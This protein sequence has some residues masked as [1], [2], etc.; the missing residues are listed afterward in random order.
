MPVDYI[1]A[2]DVGTSSTK[3][4]LVRGDGAIEAWGAVN[5]STSTPKPGWAEQDPAR[6]WDAVCTNTRGLLTDRPQATGRIAAI[7][8][9]GHMLGCLPL[10]REAAPLRP[11]MIHS[12]TRAAAECETIRERVGA[13]T[14]Y[15]TTGNILGPQSP[16]AKMLWL[17]RHE[18]DLYERTARF[19]QSK[20]YIVARMVGQANSTDFSD[21]SHA[22]LLDIRKR[23]YAVDIL[24]ELGLDAAKLPDL[25]AGTDVV[26]QLTR[27]AA[28]AMGLPAG[29]PVVAGGGDGACATAGAGAVG[30][31]DTYCCIGTTAWIAS[32]VAEPVIDEEQRVFDILSLDGETCGVFG[33]IQ[34]AGRSLDWVM[35]LIREESFDRFDEL[36][37]RVAPG[38]EGLVFL[39]YLE[40]ERSPI[41]DAD[42]RGV[43]FGLTPAH[44]REHL[45]RAT[46]EGVSFALRSVLSVMREAMPVP[47]LRLIGGGGQSPA[48]RQM[49]ADICDVKIQRLSTQAAD[50]TS[51]GAAI[52][53]G[54][55]V[56]LFESMAAAAR[57]IRIEQELAPHAARVAAYD[58]CYEVYAA[59]YPALKPIYRSL[60]EC[61]APGG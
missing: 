24:S 32:T 17:K 20:D 54:V 58:R 15:R 34:C 29:I 14:I 50:A 42:A 18:P 52:A 2:H 37:G 7:G 8:V 57:T 33:T 21:A 60:K 26:G 36:L 31:G 23:E 12:D 19:V 40:G 47:A 38:S 25:H 45:L 53:A 1:L 56:G 5:Q 48:W 44:G 4:S 39:P 6:W 61:V 30:L 11:K 46:V 27:E 55:G 22:Q 28:D 3:T 9:S 35:E 41:F 43:F 13:D 10:D 49:L 59:L 51:L 16:L